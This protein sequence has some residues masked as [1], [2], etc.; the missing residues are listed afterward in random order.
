M[1][2]V[3][4]SKRVNLNIYKLNEFENV[5]DRKWGIRKSRGFD[6]LP[7]AARPHTKLRPR[8]KGALVLQ[9]VFLDTNLGIVCMNMTM[10]T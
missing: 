2:S 8:Q 4:R 10:M 9:R 7:P 3:N 1:N 5:L 6:V